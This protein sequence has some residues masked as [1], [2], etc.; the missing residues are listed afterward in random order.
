MSL[1]ALR[2]LSEENRKVVRGFA[3]RAIP[4]VLAWCRRNGAPVRQPWLSE[5]PQTVVRHLEDAGLLDFE[6]V[7]DTQL[8]ELC[9]RA[10]GWP[11]AMP[12]TLD[13]ATLG[14]VQSAVEE[15]ERRREA[16]RQR[17]VV[18]RRSV[19]FGG[20]M[21]DTGG[22]SFSHAFLPLA[23]ESVSRDDGWWARSRS[24]PR[25]AEFAEA[26][27]GGQTRGGGPGGRTGRR[28]SPPEDQRRA[29]GLASEWLAFQYLKRRHRDAVDETCWVST[30]RVHFFGGSDGDDVAGYDFCVKTPQAEWL[31][32]VKSS[33]RLWAPAVLTW[34]PLPAASAR[35]SP[36]A[37]SSRSP[38]FRGVARESRRGRRRTRYLAGS[39]RD[40]AAETAVPTGW[41]GQHPSAP[42][43][44]LP[45]GP[46][47]P[48]RRGEAPRQPS[49][50]PGGTSPRPG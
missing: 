8:P 24:Q 15:E 40:S 35:L 44:A 26:R 30:N 21:L 25:L 42:V 17:R 1:P 29:M 49:A 9:F 18:E 45:S 14:L 34:A 4:V 38:P 32:E 19:D 41:Q 46:L 28:K 2:G 5:E 37:F 23:E 48:S 7:D 31:Y 43:R 50:S 12:R 39:V 6:P 22:P 10:A 13:T 16:E 36:R 27:A 33:L 20:T 11:K 47:W 3:S